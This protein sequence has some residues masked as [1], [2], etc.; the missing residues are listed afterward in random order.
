[1]TERCDRQASLLAA[2]L[3]TIV[4]MNVADAALTLHATGSGE[5]V[6]ANPV[7]AAALHVGAG[8]FAVVKLAVVCLG[9]LLLWWQRGHRW[10]LPA[11]AL[12]AGVFVAVVTYQILWVL[13]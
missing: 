1:M 3:I 10:V 8:T 13:S 9:V 11:A 7:M 6:E 5:V 4:V 12:L 2:L